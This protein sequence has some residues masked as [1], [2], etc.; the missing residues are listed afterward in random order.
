V[1]TVGIVASA[2]VVEYIRLELEVLESIQVVEDNVF[3]NVFEYVSVT[4]D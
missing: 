4:P 1:R 2:V 3:S